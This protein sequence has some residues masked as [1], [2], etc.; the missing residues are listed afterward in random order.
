[1]AAMGLV[2]RAFRRLVRCLGVACGLAWASSGPAAAL[3]F[4]MIS[5]ADLAQQAEVIVEGR[6]LGSA[7]ASVEGPPQTDTRLEVL[8]VLKGDVSSSVLT[9]RTLGGIHGDLVLY[10]DGAPRFADGERVILFL[11]HGPEG[12]FRVL[13]LVLGA[14]HEVEIGGRLVALRDLDGATE[15]RPL[16]DGSLILR[17]TPLDLPRDAA[18]FVSWLAAGAGSAADYFAAPGDGGR[19]LMARWDLL[20][21]PTG[22]PIRW[23]TFDTGGTVTVRVDES[24]LPGLPGGGFNEIRQALGLWTD[25]PGSS[26]R[27]AYAGTTPRTD[28][29]CAAPAGEIQ[30]LFED[31]AGAIVGTYDCQLGGVVAIG[32]ACA[33]LPVQT[34]QG[35]PFQPILDGAVTT[36]DGA[37]CF[38]ERLGVFDISPVELFTHEVG[39][40]LGLAHSTVM[41]AVMN[42]GLHRNFPNALYQDDREAIAYLYPNLGGPPPAAPSRL[43][44]TVLSS[45]QI[46]LT[47]QDNATDE[48]GFRIERRTGGGSFGEVA[49]VGANVTAFTAAGLAAATTY[50]FRVRAVNEQGFS[51]YSSTAS[52]TTAPAG[53]TVPVAPSNLTATAVSTSRINLSWRDNAANETGYRVERRGYSGFTE[54]A[55]LPAG[56]TSFAVTGLAAASPYEFRVRAANAQGL[57]A[58]SNPAS[59]NT[60]GVVGPCVAN[61]T[62][63]CLLAGALRVEVDWKNQHAG[64]ALGT[65]HAGALSTKTGSFWFFSADNVELLVKALD[66]GPV[67]GH[68]W[69][70]YGA[71]SDVEYW[72]RVTQTVTGEV[73][74]FH[75]PPGEICGAGDVSALLKSF[76]AESVATGLRVDAWPAAEAAPVAR[77]TT[78]SCTPGPQVLCLLGGRFEVRVDWVNPRNATSGTGTRVEA[79]DRSG[80]FWFFDPANLELVVKALDGR[81]QNGHFWFFYGALSDVEY[82][83]HVRDTVTGTSR[84]YDNPL[85]E[86][87]GLGDT[88]AF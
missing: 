6:V 5:D 49:S 21:G 23:F 82:H 20:N 32:R 63:L 22:N 45:S 78:A 69:F 29:L 7:S 36:Q 28:R 33:R 76:A 34:F 2:S 53:P 62:T 88:A 17:S 58:Y 70:F 72:V 14:F 16:P 54:V 37:Q 3:T 61:D 43:A 50:E 30:I 11:V 38:F 71:L 19:A 67:N 64:G 55:S 52:A 8:R 47:W 57:S 84:T 42:P 18:A 87:C 51:A 24:G 68:Y 46:A 80:Y 31:P 65:G 81:A 73:A 41:P 39:H 15:A 35:T 60:R 83:L 9:V 74:V 40:V 48:T 26:I 12:T 75:N 85:G 77:A 27:L 10:V 56:S 79:S 59:T 13:Q 44:A 86:I 66:G 4:Q 1:M 25:D